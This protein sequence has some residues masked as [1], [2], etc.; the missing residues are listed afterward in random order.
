MMDI[1]NTVMA[2]CCGIMIPKGK[3][4][5]FANIPHFD[6]CDGICQ[7]KEKLDEFLTLFQTYFPRI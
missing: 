3:S 4:K 6:M 5:K 2:D 1:H 7:E